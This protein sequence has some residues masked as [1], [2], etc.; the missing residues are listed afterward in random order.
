MGKKLRPRRS[1]LCRCPVRGLGLVSPSRSPRRGAGPSQA[2]PT[3]A[4]RAQHSRGVRLSRQRPPVVLLESLGIHKFVGGT[5]TTTR[6]T[7]RLQHVVPGQPVDPPPIDG[8]QFGRDF[9]WRHQLPEMQRDL[10][11]L[12]VRVATKAAADHY[13]VRRPAPLVPYPTAAPLPKADMAKADQCRILNVYLRPW[14]A[15]PEDATWHAPHFAALDTPISDMQQQPSRRCPNKTRLGQRCHA[16][17]SLG[18]LYSESHRVHTRKT[19][20]QQLFG[21]G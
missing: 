10:V 1:V 11:R 2:A 17:C 14:T 5:T 7:F 9:V 21:S 13:L 3:P 4:L 20:D 15:A 19:P 18:R 12:P 16:C 8:F 6:R